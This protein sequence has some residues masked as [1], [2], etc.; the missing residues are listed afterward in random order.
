[1]DHGDEFL[2]VLLGRRP[3]TELK[4]SFFRFAFHGRTPAKESRKR[5]G[6]ITEILSLFDA[7]YNADSYC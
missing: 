5:R 4:P 1:V 6:E 2:R 7:H 3:P